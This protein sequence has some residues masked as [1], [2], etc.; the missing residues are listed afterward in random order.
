M[1]IFG[2]DKVAAPASV[3]FSSPTVITISLPLLAVVATALAIES[4]DVALKP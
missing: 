3:I 1:I 4:V 2:E